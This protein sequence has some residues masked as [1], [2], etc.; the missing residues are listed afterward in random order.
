MSLHVGYDYNIL[1]V[2]QTTSL[3]IHQIEV[4]FLI[5]KER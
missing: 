3:I 5:D 4:V 2:E 1:I